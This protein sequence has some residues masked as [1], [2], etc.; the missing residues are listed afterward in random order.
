M[1]LRDQVTQQRS[2][3][4]KSMDHVAGGDCL[5]RQLRELC[6]EADGVT[7]RKEVVQGVRSMFSD[8]D[9]ADAVICSTIHKAKGL[10]A[11]RAFMYRTELMYPKYVKSGTW[12]YDQE[13][14]LDYVARTRGKIL[15]GY[16]HGE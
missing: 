12:Q 10:E 14:N 15:Y 6:R 7:G 11:D 16:L 13:K 9:H 8:D 3:R 1:E 5:K 2:Q 4:A